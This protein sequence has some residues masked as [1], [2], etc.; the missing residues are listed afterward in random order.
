MKFKAL[1]I[2]VA[3]MMMLSAALLVFSAPNVVADGFKKETVMSS[4]TVGA[5]MA[6]DTDSQ[7]NVHM[8]FYDDTLQNL[9]YANNIGGSWNV[10]VAD[11]SVDI[12]STN[13]HCSIAVDKWDNVH[14]AY[15]KWNGATSTGS[16][17]YL[18]RT[19][20]AWDGP[21][22]VDSSTGSD[23]GYFNSIAVD[24]IG[25]IH[26]ANFDNSAHNLRYSKNSS[27]TLSFS[28]SVIVATSLYGYFCT[29]SIGPDDLPQ[30]AYYSAAGIP[31]GGLY[32]SKRTS[33]STTTWSTPYL[34][35]PNIGGGVFGYMSRMVVGQDN[36][37]RILYMWNSGSWAMKYATGSGASWIISDLVAAPMVLQYASVDISSGGDLWFSYDIRKFVDPPGPLPLN[38]YRVLYLTKISGAERTDYTIDYMSD[39]GAYGYSSV[40]LDQTG[41]PHVGYQ[42]LITWDACY[43]RF[44]YTPGPA[45]NVQIA[46]G[47]HYANVTWQEPSYLDDV[48][49]LNY[50]VQR[51][52]VDNTSFSNLS[53]AV[54]TPPAPLYY[55][56]TTVDNGVE[57]FYRILTETVGGWSI[58]AEVSAVPMT[59]PTAP[60]NPTAVAGNRHVVVGWD[61]PSDSGG[62][63]ILGYNIY[64]S[65]TSGGPYDLVNTTIDGSVFSFN[66]TGLVNGATYYYIVSVFTQVGEGPTSTEVGDT[67]TSIPAAPVFTPTPGN[68]VVILSWPAVTDTGGLPL[69]G[70]KVYE[71]PNGGVYGAPVTL[72]STTTEYTWSALVNGDTYWFKVSAFNSKG[73][74]ISA[75]Q[76]AVPMAVPSA[77]QNPSATGGLHLVSLSW[78]APTDT[79]GSAI[80]N[81]EIYRGTSLG[82]INF[83]VE[84]GNVLVYTDTSVA[85]GTHYYYKIA[86]KNAAGIGLASDVRDATTFGVP[87]APQSPSAL[88]QMNNVH[89]T[90]S[91]PSDTG[92]SAITGYRVWKGTSPGSMTALPDLGVVLVYDDSAGT[93]GVTYYYKVA[94]KNAVGV[95]TESATVN[96]MPFSVPTVPQSLSAAEGRG[97]VTLTWSAS[98][99]D[100]GSAII[101][102]T[103]LRRAGSTGVFS[104]LGAVTTAPWEYVDAAVTNG[105]LYEYIVMAYNAHGASTGVSDSA[106]PHGV[107]A[108]PAGLFALAGNAQVGLTWNAVT[109]TGGSP[110]LNYTIYRRLGTSGTFERVGNTTSASQT[111]YTNIGLTNGQE[112]SYVVRAFNVYGASADSNIV[113]ATPKTVPSAPQSV[114]ASADGMAIKIT[115]SAPSSTGGSAIDGYKVLRGGVV[116][117]TLGSGATSFKDSNV[118]QGQKYSYTVTAHNLVGDGAASTAAE[119]TAPSDST[120][121]IIIVVVVVVVAAAG[122]GAFFFL[123]KRKG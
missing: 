90:W 108:A 72:L 28:S 42:Q 106:T 73:E 6:I 98:A 85:D 13:A 114:A 20:M 110:I 93:P 32:H 18:K 115:W 51:S 44:T 63:P 95:G 119:I 45:E 102:Y 15:R 82:S 31:L 49:V 24:S 66:N 99:S 101:N 77:P 60:L 76:S 86:A 112:Y 2:G 7:N 122:A 64:R 30:I 58:S 16:L 113:T 107:P 17:M 75:E 26:I 100:G 70:Y 41:R 38:T 103:I 27:G 92:G 118:T 1:A 22:V 109:D 48:P 104:F 65:T 78:T 69:L 11:G 97:T 10:Y 37:A 67:P 59:A 68:G 87:S 116:I 50:Y 5:N 39:S 34:V 19:G 74:N 62:F 29:L 54:I 55:N 21:V 121:L 36:V 52:D 117:A 96:A 81:Y 79:G 61:P 91:A 4:G 88:G 83:L 46:S 89:L 43:A 56:D 71:R 9:M 33:I 3:L 120:M 8:V 84:V 53:G 57:Y 12:S 94:A 105:Q 40:S 111:S 47:N 80:T 25:T 14:I 35:D 123:K 23:R